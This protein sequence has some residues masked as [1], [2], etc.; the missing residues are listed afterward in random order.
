M[1]E[2]RRHFLINKP[3]Q[4]RL[5]SYV[6]VTLLIVSAAIVLNLYFGIW[7]NVLET[8]SNQET[9]N[10]LLTAARLTQYEEAR[11]PSSSNAA[12]ELPFLKQTEK[13]SQ[14]QREIFKEI[15]VQTN[16]KLV[17]NIILLLLFIAG[18][19]IFITHTIAGPLYRFYE[20]LKELE[21][22]NL[23]SRIHLRKY[24]EAKFIE[25]GF[26]QAME[27]LETLFSRIKKILRDK[28]AD[29]KKSLSLISEE[30]SKI[31]TREDRK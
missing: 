18:G 16:R 13:L 14:R 26:N 2:R 27:N 22:G 1:P 24:D 8:F 28:E 6:T 5:M 11:L 17:P 9:L 23:Y 12:P 10:D 7:G 21:K 19:S 29:P 4:L 3:F 20:R 15:L 25:T 31:K 30:I